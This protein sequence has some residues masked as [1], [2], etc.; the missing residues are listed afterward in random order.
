MARTLSEPSHATREG[1][2]RQRGE[3]AEQD[4]KVE[5]LEY[6]HR[7]GV[8]KAGQVQGRQ[9]ELELV[10]L[11]LVLKLLSQGLLLCARVSCLHQKWHLRGG[12][13]LET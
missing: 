3:D 5:D 8:K 13:P 7:W 1:Q 11:A 9:K 6:Y 12:L 2:G 10:P 4:E